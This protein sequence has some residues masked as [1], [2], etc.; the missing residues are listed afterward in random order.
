MTKPCGFIISQLWRLEVQ[1][2]SH[3]GHAVSDHPRGEWFISNR[4]SLLASCANGLFESL[5]Y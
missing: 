5:S 3:Q 2:R 1:Y 4:D